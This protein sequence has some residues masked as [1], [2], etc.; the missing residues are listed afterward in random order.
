MVP[1]SCPITDVVIVDFDQPILD[2]PLEDADLQ[3]G[4]E[5]LREQAE[6]IHTHE[7]ILA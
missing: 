1:V 4:V 7:P 2:G 6:N 3:I 5:Y